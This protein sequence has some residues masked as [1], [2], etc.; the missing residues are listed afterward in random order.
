MIVA[1]AHGRKPQSTSA[2]IEIWPE[3]LIDSGEGIDFVCDMRIRG[4]NPFESAR[5]ASLGMTEVLP[6]L[7]AQCH[8]R[9]QGLHRDGGGGESTAHAGDFYS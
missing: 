3:I 7:R 4:L 1:A 6:I 5:G 2:A 9:G 8:R